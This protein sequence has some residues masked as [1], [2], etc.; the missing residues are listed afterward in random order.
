MKGM[1]SDSAFLWAFRGPNNPQIPKNSL[2]N[3]QYE[4]PCTPF[5]LV[6]NVVNCVKKQRK[7]DPWISKKNHK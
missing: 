5:S 4:Y 2:E 1:L 6:P 7:F 3:I